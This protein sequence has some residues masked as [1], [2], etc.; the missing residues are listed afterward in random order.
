MSTRYPPNLTPCLLTSRVCARWISLVPAIQSR[1]GTTAFVLFECRFVV[2]DGGSSM[3]TPSS[4]RPRRHL[5]RRCRDPLRP[6]LLRLARPVE[7]HGLAPSDPKR[8][9]RGIL[10][11][12]CSDLP[13]SPRLFAGAT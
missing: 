8:L 2:P 5:P 4:L 10:G 12:F 7:G 9:R 6:L 13:S 3:L 11:V 1:T